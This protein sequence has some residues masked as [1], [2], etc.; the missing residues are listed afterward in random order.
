MLRFVLRDIAL[1]LLNL[2][3]EVRNLIS[4]RADLVFLIVVA[5]SNNFNPVASQ[6][7][8]AFT[9]RT[10][11]KTAVYTYCNGGTVDSQYG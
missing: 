4:Q 10:E 7:Y 8:T 1:A 11:L 6:S 9:S 3:I 5:A 2:L